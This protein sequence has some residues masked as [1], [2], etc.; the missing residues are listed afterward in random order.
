MPRRTRS[1]RFLPA[2]SLLTLCGAVFLQACEEET[3]VGPELP[4]DGTWEMIG[5]FSDTVGFARCWLSGTLTLRSVGGGV[6]TILGEGDRSLECNVFGEQQI[7]AD[8]TTLTNAR[9]Q[10]TN[11]SLT[12]GECSFGS[13]Y[14]PT[15]SSFMS[16]IAGCRIWPSALGGTDVLGSW[17]GHR[18]TEITP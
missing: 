18:V 7:W 3:P 2:L 16:G 13:T 5:I 14:L 11:L 6:N 4:I 9:Y 17:E 8:T 10:G 1:R 12:L 15:E